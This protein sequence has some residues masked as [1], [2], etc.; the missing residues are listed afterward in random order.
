MATYRFA[1]LILSA[2]FPVPELPRATGRAVLRVSL[3]TRQRRDGRHSW[4]HVWRLP[5]RRA[6][7]RV[8]RM[9]RGHLVQFPGYAEFE[10]SPAAIVCHPRAGVPIATVRHLLLDQL[11]PAILTS[12]ARLVLHASAVAIRG[13]AIGFLGTA[14]VGKSTVAA[15]L[16]RG[17]ASIVTDDALVLDWNGDGV[18]A[19]P[20]YPGLRLWPDSRR[21]LGSWRPIRRARVAHYSRKERWSGAGVPFCRSRLPLRALY[22]VTPGNVCRLVPLSAR[23]SMLALVRHSMMLDAT[24]PKTIKQ[25]FELAARLVDRVPV[26]RLI[27]P[28]GAKA[29]SDVCRSVFDRAQPNN[30]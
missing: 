28:P 16:V 27:V 1:G 7:M 2:D 11:L 14:G 19:V 20:S 23:Q 4:R 24:D 29:L 8:A 21:L 15:A 12:R 9:T 25:G 10:V 3:G 22:V 17:G 6:W 30:R 5:D 26:A 18:H 13:G